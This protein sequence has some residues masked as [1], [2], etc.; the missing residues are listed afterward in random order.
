[1][2]EQ[3]MKEWVLASRNAHKAEELAAMLNGRVRINALPGDWAGIDIPENEHTFEGNSASKALFVWER[4]QQSCLADD[5][6]IEVYV[7]NGEPGVHSARYSPTGTDQD[8]LNL[9]LTN[10]ERAQ[11]RR[12]RFRCV[13]SLVE[14]GILKQFEGKVEGHLTHHPQGQGGFG[15]DPIFVPDGFDKTFSELGAHVKNSISHRAKAV[16]K[17]MEYLSENE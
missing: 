1:M 14:N 15:Y 7:L 9:L 13:I 16:K 10:M 11:D 2:A 17:L 12:A 4:L 5:S 3:M 8:N 6:G